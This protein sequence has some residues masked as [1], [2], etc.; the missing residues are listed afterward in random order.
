MA[1][2]ALQA[3]PSPVV[4]EDR[5]AV[6]ASDE[7]LYDR[8]DETLTAA[9]FDIADVSD[10]AQLDALCAAAGAGVAVVACRREELRRPGRLE[11]LRRSHPD[12]LLVIVSTGE[13]RHVVRDAMSFGAEGYVCESQLEASLSSTVSAVIAGCICVPRTMR[14]AVVR[15]AFT[16]R[17]RQVLM[18]VWRGLSNHEIAQSLFLSESTVK[19]HLASAFRKLGV[20]SRVEAAALLSDPEELERV[21]GSNVE[22]LGHSGGSGRFARE[23]AAPASMWG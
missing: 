16:R 12:L 9:G 5:V 2:T 18:L 7:A 6:L 14:R 17:E 19:S 22:Y 4:R 15:V 13:T 8:I 10:L 23:Q 21:A 20:T 1:V 11:A 3:L